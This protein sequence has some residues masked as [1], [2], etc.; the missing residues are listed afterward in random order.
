ML[1]QHSF[2][3]KT[4]PDHCLSHLS[5]EQ[6]FSKA[7]SVELTNGFPEPR[8]AGMVGRPPEVHILRCRVHASEF[9]DEALMFEPFR[10]MSCN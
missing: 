4:I 10:N 1:S 6:Q 7:V 8:E 9:Q 2:S 5:K 3:R